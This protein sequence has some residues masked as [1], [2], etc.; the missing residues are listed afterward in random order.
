MFKWR[1]KEE[2][3]RKIRID[4]DPPIQ[5]AFDSHF[6][7]TLENVIAITSLLGNIGTWDIIS[8]KARLKSTKA[9]TSEIIL[10]CHMTLICCVSP[11][12]NSSLRLRGQSCGGAKHWV[13]FNP[14]WVFGMFATGLRCKCGEGVSGR[15]WCVS[16]LCLKYQVTL[17]LDTGNF[18]SPFCPAPPRTLTSLC[19]LGR[20]RAC[21][22]TANSGWVCV[23]IYAW[24]MHLYG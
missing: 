5:A 24:V 20:Y 9:A 18:L 16:L 22:F 21:P 1:W 23:G 3:E 19:N 13:Y 14:V 6:C 2:H 11:P 4:P 7:N 15:G 8:M 17:G 12:E 10:T